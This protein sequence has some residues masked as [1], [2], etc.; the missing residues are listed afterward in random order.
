MQN[1]RQYCKAENIPIISLSTENFLKDVLVKYR[2]KYCLE[3]WTAIGYSALVIWKQVQKW[4]WLLYTFELWYTSY[5]QA[6]KNF[7][8][9][10]FY[11]VVAYNLD[12]LK[13]PIE[14]YFPFKFDFIFIDWIKK[15]YKQFLEKSLK[16][17][18]Q[19][20]ILVFDDVIKFKNKMKDFYEFLKNSNLDWQMIKLDE[21][22]GILLLKLN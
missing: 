4:N 13:I 3:I 22:D 2:P 14:R 20:A 19:G 15:Y 11:N 16:V 1:L 12:F 9:Q 7:E 10:S 5:R 8:K 17:A 21:D 6:L 18:N